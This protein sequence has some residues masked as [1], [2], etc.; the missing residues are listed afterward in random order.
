MITNILPG[1]A[2]QAKDGSEILD[3]LV[4]VLHIDMSNNM[5]LVIPLIPKKSG[6]NGINKRLYFV[7]PKVLLLDKI[8]QEISEHKL[9]LMTKSVKP[10][11]D[12]LA[13]DDELDR[14]Y[15]RKGQSISTPRKKRKDR[16]DII[17]PLV[18]DYE[19]RTLILD[20]QVRVELIKKR[21]KELT[22]KTCSIQRTIKYVSEI[23]NQYLAEGSTYGAVTPFS[24]S[25][26]GRGKEKKTK[27]NR[28]LGKP[29][30]PTKN[31]IKNTAGYIMSEEDKDIC[32]FAWRNY[33]IRGGTIAKALRKM[34]RE[35]YSDISINHKG[36]A[37]HTLK[38]LNNRPT[39]TQFETWGK[40]RSPGH[41]SWKKQF[42]K[43]NLN[44]LNRV[45]FSTSDA[46]VTG[47]GQRG[48]VDSTSIDLELV[49][50]AFRLDRIGS[51]HRILI[52]DS[53]FG[54]IPGFYLGI[55]APSAD[56]VG[57]AFLHSLSDKTEWLNWLGLSD[58]SPNDWIP[59]RFGTVLA[60]NT[61]LR[62]DATINKLD[63]IGTGIKFVGV[64]RSDLNSPVETAH[65]TLHRLVDHNLHG[66]THGQRLERGEELPS[67]LAR[68]TIIEATREIARAIHL[69][70]TI[71]L[72]MRPTLEM[73]RD[74]VDKGI[75]LTRAN[76]TRWKINQGKCFTSLISLD[77]ALIKLLIP[78]RGTFTQYG[79]K[80]LRPDTGNKREFIE[81]LKYTSH[82]NIIIARVMK[83]K[84]ERT[85]VSAQSHD[86]IFLH[87]PYKPTEIY[88]KDQLTAELIQLKLN[89]KD[90]DLPHECSL[91]DIIDLMNRDA[92]HL[93]GVKESRNHVLSELEAS[94]ERTKNEAENAYQE[95]LSRE[96]K[97]RSKASLK[98]NKKENRQLEKEIL[99]Y[100][101]PI[102]LSDSLNSQNCSS[103][104]TESNQNAEP[105]DNLS[106]YPIAEIAVNDAKHSNQNSENVLLNAMLERKKR[107]NANV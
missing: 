23:L 12:V 15:L 17:K 57:L 95:T 46:D 39:R 47:V 73:R 94:Q 1:M 70:N 88:F 105:L 40:N 8:H 66:T 67:L 31:G 62:S 45:L 92:L 59:I 37:I 49:S 43:F 78:I 85:K 24:A 11:A 32:G 89:I 99:L 18:H 21:A 51:A 91:P 42:T 96:D 98:S 52:V 5:A 13:T 56:T 63:S 103:C 97:P 104:L 4:R 80:L 14:K 7:G 106:Q 3:C 36:Q 107:R 71:E 77:E 34:W 25:Q 79:V 76:L 53:L 33:Y 101:M 93:F 55:E 82:H 83:A 74:L 44:R 81:P 41:E 19:N 2:I 68:H 69:H 20:P 100:G 60:D 65:H 87:N 90:T 27:K 6:G 26:G 58:Q 28:K 22:N 38:G 86:D 48:A 84:V 29:N 54:Y 61:D 16:Y 30:T 75:K 9:H 50:V 102:P 64:A 10:R 35:F 72:D